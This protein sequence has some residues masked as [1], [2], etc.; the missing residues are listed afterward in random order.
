MAWHRG[1]S[2]CASLSPPLSASVSVRRE[3]IGKVNISVKKTG[4]ETEKE[5]SAGVSR[6][7]NPHETTEF[8]VLSSPSS[9]LPIAAAILWRVTSAV[10]FLCSSFSKNQ[11]ESSR[12]H[13]IGSPVSSR[14]LEKNS[15]LKRSGKR[16][17]ARKRKP[18]TFPSASRERNARACFIKL[19][20]YFLARTVSSFEIDAVLKETIRIVIK[21]VNCTKNLQTSLP[22]C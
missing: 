3:C 11:M 9:I 19:L 5:V 15:R 20:K 7:F 10:A 17:V 1:T 14:E 12:R 4:G 22:V 13:G 18:A 16:K 21:Y 2:H 8:P 6:V